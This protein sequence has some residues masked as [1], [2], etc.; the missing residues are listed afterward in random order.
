MIEKLILLLLICAGIFLIRSIEKD[1]ERQ[2]K[3]IEQLY[4]R[5][6]DLEKEVK[7]RRNFSYVDLGA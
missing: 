3:Q 5:I 2:S 7:N 4:K 6:Y 1:F